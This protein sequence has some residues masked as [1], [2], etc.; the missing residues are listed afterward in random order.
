MTHL[1]LM[2]CTAVCLAAA[3]SDPARA[4]QPVDFV[5][6]IQ[7]ILRD[8]CYECHGVKKQEAGL[9]WDRKI[10]AFHAAD[11]G[12]MPLVPGKPAESKI[13]KAV[14]GDGMDRM[15]KDGKSLSKSQ[16]ALLERW[17]AEGAVWP[18]GVDPDYPDV[19]RYWAF[20]APVKAELPAVQHADWPKSGLDYFI[21]AKLEAA[22]LTPMPEADRYTLIRRLSL[23]LTGLPPTP[24]EVTR[25]V[26]DK[27]P[28]AY[29]H[30]VDRLLA[31]P[32]Y[33]ERWA[34]VWL[35]LARYA[36][37]Q[38]YEKDNR[39][40]G[41]WR[42]RDWVIKAYNQDMPY[43]QF[44]ID[45][46]AGDLLPNATS[47]QILATAFHRNTMTNTEGGTDDEEFRTAAVMD[48]VD[49]TG[50]VWM[51]L[52]FGCAKCH[53][54]KYDPITQREYYQMFAFFNQSDDADRND[55]SPRMA[56]PTDEQKQ[57]TDALNARLAELRGGLNGDDKALREAQAKWEKQ[58]AGGAAQWT[59]LTPTAATSAN[60]TK[61][62]VQ[63][64]GSLVASGDTPD[65]DAY[66]VS[67]HT[68][69]RHIT[70][71]RIEAMSDDSLPSRGPGRSGNGNFVLSELRVQAKP[72]HAQA[73]Q[74]ARFVR[75]DLPG[76]QRI[77]HLA[78]VQAF[79]GGQNIAP[80]GTA[81]QV[82]TDFGGDA[83]RAID[84]NTDGEYTHNSV[85]HCAVQDD[86]WWEVDLGGAKPIEK[87][88]VFNRTDNNLAPRLNG[89][90][91]SLL[92]AD[93]KVIWERTLAEAPKTSAELAIGDSV[94][95]RL[96]H[97]SATFEQADNSADNPFHGWTAA[98]AI[99]NDQ[100]SA[101]WGW[102]VSPR[103]GEDHAAVFQTA[104]DIGFD[105]GTDLTLT[106]EQNYGNKHT[107][108]RFRVSVTASPRPVRT[109]PD[110]VADA[111]AIAPAKRS[112]AQ[113][114][115]I[116]D[117]YRSISPITSESKQQIAA[118]EK[119]LKG[120]DAPTTP[121]M[122]ELP[123]GKGRT[124]H[125]LIKGNFLNPGNEVE[126]DVPLAFHPFPKDAPHNRLGL[127]QWL[128]ARDNPLTARV[129]V[130]RYWACFFGMGIVETEEDFG[131]QGTEPTHPKALD[132]MAV[133]LMDTAHWSP[134]ALCKMIVMSATY[135]QSSQVSEASLAKDPRNELL[136]HGP[137]FRLSAE[138]VRDQ[139]L[140][141]AG[142]LS[143]KMYGDSVMPPQ[144]DNVWQMVYSGDK[145]ATSKGEDKYRRGLYTFIRRTSPYPS[146]I[147][148]DG[149][150]REVCTIRR[151]R[152]NTPLQA[153]VGM[154]DPVYVEAA[155][156][157]ARRIMTDGGSSIEDRAAFAFSLVEIR[158][159][160]KREIAM[161][162]N[163]Y[164]QELAYYKGESSA[165]MALATSEL[166]ALPKDMNA[167]EAAAWT[168]VANTILNLDE[169]I[170]KG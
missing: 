41:I 20:V 141:C 128:V 146:M 159:P 45:Q 7:P 118:I 30:L 99:D 167:A 56:M 10:Y 38:G 70:A 111:L 57:K 62:A 42:Y 97:A 74:P 24:E 19:P 69:L 156:A 147:T 44:T 39:R 103:F 75:I 32:A 123:A 25:F 91:V 155:Q 81:K 108:G 1:R 157:M 164:K 109:L 78:E 143:H 34:R 161:L 68:D 6:D 15:P 14:R 33:G 61:L 115:T 40:P 104:G 92:D 13:L 136:S 112:D 82:S 31:S 134:K 65:T 43:D 52:T 127:A 95:V 67:V 131:H 102:A 47:D 101:K 29:E 35:D 89:A 66:T 46:L 144:P 142:L 132:W 129:L 58:V 138:M 145:W 22:G 133:E 27:D 163:L 165:A 26:N 36:D 137:R 77:L 59:T 87:V 3:V 140:A 50:Q 18:D 154:N 139:A 64:D 53:S 9:R 83:K 113:R 122:K 100:S 72:A 98:A 5:R 51:G 4:A 94:G 107:L 63:A 124:T 151:I 16:I 11:S 158:P 28:A 116:A 54:H 93:H 168:V 96:E 148:F 119:E 71:V 170:T 135:R 152:T 105:G 90:R 60:G 8:A 17:I 12:D 153:L 2:L 110:D 166:G 48:R 80:L 88:V 21:L 106:L 73:T 23:D 55:D 37:T 125:M 121:I 126:A 120:I 85:S 49:T 86:P 79:S 114:K 149:T 150:S 130:N 84:G 160:H 169:T 76:K 162:V 117:Y